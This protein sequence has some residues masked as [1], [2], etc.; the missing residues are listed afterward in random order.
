LVL[1]AAALSFVFDAAGDPTAVA[2]AEYTLNGI[3]P[4]DHAA[5]LAAGLGEAWVI[6]ASENSDQ[7]KVDAMCCE[8]I[9]TG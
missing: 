4:S 6:V 5:Q 2:A 1:A 9:T 7:C 3:M 8:V